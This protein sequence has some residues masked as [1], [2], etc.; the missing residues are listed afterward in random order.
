MIEIEED[1]DEV[2]EVNPS[3]TGNLKSVKDL[4]S[5]FKKIRNDI[6]LALGMKFYKR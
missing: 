4:Y 1:I 6:E 5:R 3:H 2:D